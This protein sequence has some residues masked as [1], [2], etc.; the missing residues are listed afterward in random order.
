LCFDG[1]FNGKEEK[2]YSI[3]VFLAW[4]LSMAMRTKKLYEKKRLE[5][6]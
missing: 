5:M 6:A 4:N 1:I 2:T 3:F